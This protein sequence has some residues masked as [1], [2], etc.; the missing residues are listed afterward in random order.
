ML[1]V[2]K[3]M[4][5]IT[6]ICMQ[7]GSKLLLAL[8]IFIAG[9]IVIDHIMKLVKKIHA[10][11]RADKTVAGFIISGV[12][13]VL[14]IVLLL[15]IISVLGVPMASVI[16]ILASAGMAI[17]LSLQG[18]LSNIAGGIMLLIFRPFNVGEYIQANGV[19][20]AVRA[21]SIMYTTLLTNDNKKIMIPNGELMNKSIT[22]FSSEEFRRVDLQ[23]STGKGE[24]VVKVQNI[25]LEVMKNHAKVLTDSPAHM[26]FASIDGGTNES[27]IFTARAWVKTGDY[28][29]VYYELLQEI[30]MSLGTAG[31]SA[32]EMK[33]LVKENQK[34]AIL[35]YT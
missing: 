33:V 32:P 34:N 25:L 18:A 20:G 4:S 24:D 19:E 12:K 15:S 5:E 17:G 28:W 2:E 7:A 9:R 29:T 1:D 22:N 8:V 13:I 23:F 10:I 35:H 21:I 14:N 26:P 27:I 6:T 11:D 16:T 3:I 31:I 30:T